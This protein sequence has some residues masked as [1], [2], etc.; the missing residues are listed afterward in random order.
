LVLS[1]VTVAGQDIT[2]TVG[3]P[4]DQP[5]VED[6]TFP[7]LLIPDDV[8]G[9]A[10]SALN[11]T[12]SGEVVDVSVEV[13]II[14][15][16]ISD[17]KVSLIGPDGAEVVLHDHD[18]A[19]GDDIRKS[20]DSTSL[21]ALANFAGKEV[22]GDWS[23][24]IVD[25]ASEDVGRLL[26]WG[27]KIRYEKAAAAVTGAVNPNLQ[28]PDNDSQGI[29]SDIEIQADGNVKTIAVDIDIEHTYIGDLRIDLASP[30]GTVVRLHNQ[31]GA[32]NHNIKKVYDSTS[33]LALDDF[34]GE[35]I[36]GAWQ[37]RVRDLAGQ[38]VGTLVSWGLVLG[39]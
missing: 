28:I 19:D 26:R 10:T 38:D 1:E 9:G 5:I 6:E 7:D 35:A 15:S 22:Q 21:P 8:P 17:L 23:L 16:W 12:A 36:R 11:I 31:Q 2:F 30:A 27:I 20:Y 24:F 32:S 29:S 34:S 14:H 33:T 3:E 4:Q 39:S 37:L 13:E 25:T 18:G